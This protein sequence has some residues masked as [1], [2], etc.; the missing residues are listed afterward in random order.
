MTIDEIIKK[1]K[2][3]DEEMINL[4]AALNKAITI[5]DDDGHP[6]KCVKVDDLLDLPRSKKRDDDK[7]ETDKPV[8][9][10]GLIKKCICGWPPTVRTVGS[11]IVVITCSSPF[12]YPKRE[13]YGYR[14]NVDDLVSR[15]NKL[16]E[17]TN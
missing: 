3:S 5:Y 16:Q 1:N 7:K 4:N 17:D 11:E 14:D 13:V 10:K 2:I 9:F 12:H 8:V 15:W 6:R